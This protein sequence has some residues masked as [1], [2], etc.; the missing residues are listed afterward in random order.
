MKKIFGIFILTLLIAIFILPSVFACTGFTYDDENNVFAC[1]NNDSGEFNFNI[2]FFPAEDDR[3]GRMFFD[4]SEIQSDGTILLIPYAGMNDQGCWFS[5]YGTPTLLPVNSSDKPIFSNSDCFY[6]DPTCALAEYFMSTSSDIFEIIDIIDD[7]NLEDWSYFQV[8]IADKNGNSAIIEGD[9]IIYKEGNFQVVSN[10]LQSHPELG[11]NFNAFERYDTAVSMLEN[12]TELS[13]D[14]FRDIL[15]AT[16]LGGTVYSMVYDLSNQIM[17]LYYL[18]DFE[19]TA[20]INLNE[21]LDKGEHCIC[22]GALFEPDGNQPPEKPEPPTG[23]ESG[24][25]GEV[26]EYSIVKTSDPDRDKIS[27]IIDW[28]DGNQSFWV[29]NSMGTIKLSHNWTER[30]TYEIRV[31]ARDIYGSESEWSDPLT[32]TMPKSINICNPWLLRLIQRFPIFEKILNQI[33]L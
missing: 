25:P 32:V 16:H 3:N 10:F 22:F 5:V 30:G 2:R 12:M 9:D 23:N 8:F 7:Y 21:E 20:V 4:I 19:K 14:Y 18:H 13:V 15:D 24:V 33:T 29:Y 6:K 1:C 17:N 31:K 28:G 27:Y 11:G 26:I